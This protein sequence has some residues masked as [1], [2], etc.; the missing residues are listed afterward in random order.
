MNA[1]LN[2]EHPTLVMTI[3]VVLPIA[4]GITVAVKWIARNISAGRVRMRW[5]DPDSVYE[6]E[7]DEE[8]VKQN[9][10]TPTRTIMKTRPVREMK[11]PVYDRDIRFAKLAHEPH[12]LVAGAT[13]SGKSVFLNTMLRNI[14]DDPRRTQ[15]VF[16]DLKIVEMAMYKDAP[17]TLAYCTTVEETSTTLKSV[18]AIIQERYERMGE[19]GIRKWTD[20]QGSRIYIVIDEYAELITQGRKMVER[21]LMSIAQIGRAAGVHIIAATQRPTRDIITGAVKVNFDCRVA[22]RTATA[23]DSRNILDR[24]GAEKLPRYGHALVSQCGYVADWSV[25]MTSD[26]DIEDMV[27]TWIN[28]AYLA[29]YEP[30]RIA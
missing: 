11:G 4:I 8:E 23:Q 25:P 9:Y 5:D 15:F 29:G 10:T 13:G 14:W 28:E 24:N 27:N 16:I 21:E 6:E 17:Q 18:R 20:K 26:D 22:L 7:D 30:R 12:V 19:L 2:M 3:L 1:L